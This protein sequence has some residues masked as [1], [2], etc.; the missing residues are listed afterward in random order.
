MI[1][2]HGTTLEE[3]KQIL[4]TGY[5]K[6]RIKRT[7]EENP[8][9]EGTTDGYVYLANELYIAYY[10]GN[11]KIIINESKNKNVCIFELNVSTELLCADLDELKMKT[12][13]IFNQDTTVEESLRICGCVRCPND[14]SVGSAR[15]MIVPSTTNNKIPDNERMLCT[16]F[17]SLA[18]NSGVYK[19]KESIIK[20]I[21]CRYDWIKVQS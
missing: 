11:S 2:Y 3:A 9:C 12:K 1:L 7:F 5:I 10:Y 14:L 19:E 21:A 17:S 16:E 13:N 20:E 18:L 8:Y 6:C 15:Y 4:E